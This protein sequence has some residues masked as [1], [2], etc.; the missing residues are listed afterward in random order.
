MTHVGEAPP[1]IKL[2]SYEHREDAV[3]GVARANTSSTHT[4]SVHR[5]TQDGCLGKD[6]T[7]DPH[8][9]VPPLIK[10]MGIEHRE[11]TVGGGGRE[12]AVANTHTHTQCYS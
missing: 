5:D 6:R 12:H 7:Q 1:L 8:V 4:H 2:M 11:D 10:L 9:G 3:G